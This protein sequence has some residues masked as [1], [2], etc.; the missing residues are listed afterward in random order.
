MLDQ[1]PDDGAPPSA[2][3]PRFVARGPAREW[4]GGPPRRVA[5]ADGAAYELSGADVPGPPAV[6]DA[7]VMGAVARRPLPAL[8][9]DHAHDAGRGATADK[10]SIQASRRKAATTSQLGVVPK[11][12]VEDMER[13]RGREPAPTPE[14]PA[15]PPARR[16]RGGRRHRRDE[17]E[18]KDE[19]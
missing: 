13:R 19:S 7:A 15:P 3:L 17:P 4:E 16:R 11:Q 5:E 6:Q 8:E 18:S 14:S 12:I 10:P 2:S 1:C 9:R